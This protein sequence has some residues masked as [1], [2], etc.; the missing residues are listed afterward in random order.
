MMISG[1][2][3]EF[4]RSGIGYGSRSLQQMVGP[5]PVQPA[6][7][8]PEFD[9]MPRPKPFPFIVSSDLGAMDIVPLT[10]MKSIPVRAQLSN[11]L[12]RWSPPWIVT[13]GRISTLLKFGTFCTARGR[14][15]AAARTSELTQHPSASSA[16]SGRA[17]GG[18]QRPG[19]ASTSLL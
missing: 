11:S 9:R 14:E 13:P 1:V 7:Q 12:P 16:G 3:C 10:R 18:L 5:S 19:Y 2:R 17:E 8:Y 15:R 4:K 6:L